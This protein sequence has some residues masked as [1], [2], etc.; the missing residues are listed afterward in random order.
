MQPR[1][2]IQ[3]DFSG[4]A[5]SPKML[6]RDNTEVYQ[7]S[8]LLM[9]NYMPTPQGTARKAPGT[10]FIQQIDSDTVRIMPFLSAANERCLLIL[11][12]EKCEIIFNVNDR[13]RS[14]YSNIEVVSSTLLFRRRINQNHSFV[15]GLQG[16]VA[17]PVQYTGADGFPGLGVYLQR[18]NVLM[19]PRIYNDPGDGIPVA[20]LT[21]TAVVDVATNVATIR[22]QA[23]YGSNWAWRD[24]FGS[25]TFQVEV[26]ANSDYSSPLYNNLIDGDDFPDFGSI[27]YD[28]AN[29]D[30]P[31]ND[32]TGTLYVRV[33]ATAKGNS[34]T[35]FSAP[36]ILVNY[37]E[38]FANGE[39]EIRELAAPLDTPYLAGDLKDVHYVQSPYD[40]KQM[41]FTY[42]AY[43]PHELTF[44][45][46]TGVYRFEEISFTNAPTAWTG[47]NNYPATCGSI[48]GRLVLAGGAVFKT[49]PG[50]PVASSS[51]T[52][53]ATKVGD[54]DAFSAASEVDPDD[55]LEFTSVYRSPIQWV[56]GQKTLLI[57]STE[58]EYSAQP[59]SRQGV[60][61]PGDLGVFL[62]STHGSNNVQPA[63]FGEGVLFPSD[64]GYKVR[65]LNYFD[66]N[67][68]W[69]AEDLTLYNPEIC[70]SGI[71]RMVRCRNPHQMCLVLL[72]DGSLA[73]FHAEQSLSGWSTYV[74]N[75]GQI[76]DICVVP[77]DDGDDVP[78]LVVSR[79]IDGEEV[80]Y[81][82]CIPNWTERDDW[83]YTESTLF[84]QFETPTAVVSGLDHLEGK[85]VQVYDE[86]RFLGVFT[87]SGGSVTITDGTD[88][89]TTKVINV[90]VGLQHRSIMRMLPPSK[91]NPGAPM[92]FT[93]FAVRVIN[94]TRPIING[95]RPPNRRPG[96]PLGTSQRFEEFEDVEVT[97]AGWDPYQAIEV[98]EQI[99]FRN[100]IAG[101][102]ARMQEG[103]TK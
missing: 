19:R 29:F 86:S 1:V 2:N 84:F 94:S 90:R 83:D 23:R 35:E 16:W 82:E 56:Y 8:V 69:V 15:N 26:S 68:G 60:L 3:R 25:Y 5:I 14:D 100:E 41:V 40:P 36:V 92:R 22:Y 71:V 51:E 76:K 50:D 30:L 77:N 79:N 32:W 65:R 62:Q 89:G 4:G 98:S 78:Y 103:G 46:N 57:G 75:G 73:I 59:S 53:W 66:E 67:A 33:T 91:V 24:D 9:Q 80:T 6:M 81:L 64:G 47:A 7:R 21:T 48:Y 54:W 70:Q 88:E 20:T 61:T 58:Y 102:Y 95:D 49:L 34:D 72:N 87:V 99:P 28:E 52:V 45:K 85:R 96:M 13:T 18:N 101:V 10:R 17:D 74:L 11:T 12:P 55:S 42:A 31:T 63:G 27:L 93:D 39:T 44:L 38:I 97:L 43:P 37:L